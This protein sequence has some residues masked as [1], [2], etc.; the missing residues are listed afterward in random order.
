M[1]MIH[2]TDNICVLFFVLHVI[3][4]VSILVSLLHIT[5][6]SKW[7]GGSYM[8]RGLVTAISHERNDR[9]EFTINCVKR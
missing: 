8:K 9:R 1:Q 7:S 6:Y 4:R 2:N 5:V 3:E